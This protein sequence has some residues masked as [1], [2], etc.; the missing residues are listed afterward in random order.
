MD[1]VVFE[2]LAIRIAPEIS[3]GRTHEPEDFVHNIEGHAVM[4]DDVGNVLREV[5][6]FNCQFID[7][8]SAVLSDMPPSDTYDATQV[9]YDLYAGLSKNDEL[10][11]RVL[12]ALDLQRGDLP[13]SMNVVSLDR[14]V[15]YPAFRGQGFGLQILAMLMQRFRSLTN[16]Y[17]L[18]PFPLQF[19]DPIDAGDAARFGFKEFSCTLDGG[20][21]RLQRHYA[22]LGFCRVQG[23]P[24]MVRA[25]DATLP[26]PEEYMD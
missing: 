20:R 10:H 21:R 23:T 11:P 16:F 14:L 6:E 9:T 13:R 7:A 1:D 12:R 3:F 8:D 22:R 4:V 17:V 26:R 5:G 24:Y 18:K 25:T 2:E 15:V 19:E